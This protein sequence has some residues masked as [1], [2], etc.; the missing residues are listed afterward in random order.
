MRRQPGRS[1]TRN[2]VFNFGSFLKSNLTS[3]P[4]RKVIPEGITAIA[5]FGGR[6]L[7]SKLFHPLQLCQNPIS[8]EPQ[9]FFC[10]GLIDSLR[11]DHFHTSRTDHHSVVPGTRGHSP[12]VWNGFSL[13]F[14]F[15]LLGFGH[16][17]CISNCGNPVHSTL[18]WT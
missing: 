2:R 5:A 7:L 14:N 6:R 17:E 1:S 16:P 13:M 15:K 12:L 9:E 10:L 11:S 4:S 8:M 3:L 18:F